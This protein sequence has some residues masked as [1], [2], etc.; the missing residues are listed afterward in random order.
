[1]KNWCAFQNFPLWFLNQ[2]ERTELIFSGNKIIYI[3]YIL[4]QDGRDLYQKSIHFKNIE[5]IGVELLPGEGGW[6]HTRALRRVRRTISMHVPTWRGCP[7][8]GRI[9]W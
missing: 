4:T 5:N 8:S 6:H 1:M 9:V 2:N 3:N 7:Q